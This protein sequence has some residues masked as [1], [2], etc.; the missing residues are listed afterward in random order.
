M[1]GG[2]RPLRTRRR[3]GGGRDEPDPARQPRGPRPA[4]AV[5]RGRTDAAIGGDR[6]DGGPY[7][8][9][10]R[11]G[12][13]RRRGPVVELGGQLPASELG[14]ALAVAEAMMPH[15][16]PELLA[17]P[18]APTLQIVRPPTASVVT[19]QPNAPRG[20]LPAAPP[21]GATRVGGPTPP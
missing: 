14:I 2:A 3:G 4:R 9:G 7:S 16:P 8:V 5:R 12:R 13:V 11:A 20:P 15:P 1:G 6:G 19:A 17:A 21:V 10:A 18:G